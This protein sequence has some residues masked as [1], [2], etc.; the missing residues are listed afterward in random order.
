MTRWAGSGG[1]GAVGVVQHGVKRPGE[2]V[3]PSAAGVA[4]RHGEQV[5][6]QQEEQQEEVQRKS[7]AEHPVE[8]RGGR[9][10][11]ALL[12][13]QQR[14]DTNVGIKRAT[15]RASPEQLRPLRRG[16]FLWTNARAAALFWFPVLRTKRDLSDLFQHMEQMLQPFQY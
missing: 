3:G 5:G 11:V 6:E 9:G 2:V 16:D 1:R 14:R 7:S 4:L 15:I 8:E 12:S 13:A 10:G